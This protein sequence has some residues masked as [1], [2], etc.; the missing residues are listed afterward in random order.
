MGHHHHEAQ[1]MRLS[2][3]VAQIKPQF[4]LFDR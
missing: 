1:S 3:I 4:K 2:L